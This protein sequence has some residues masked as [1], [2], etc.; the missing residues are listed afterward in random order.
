MAFQYRI[1]SKEQWEARA[2]QSGGDYEGWLKDEYKIY[3]TLVNENCIRI[4]PPS[5]QWDA[6]SP[7]GRAPHYGMDVYVHFGVGPDNASVVCPFKM[8]KGACPVCEERA[9]YE[10]A[11]DEEMSRKL[12]AGKRVL[13]FLV[14]RKDESQGPV[15]W[16]M[17]YTL[18]RD[19][20]KASKDRATGTHYFIDDPAEGFDVYFDRTGESLSTK[21]SGIVLAKSPSPVAEQ[22]LDWVE[23][24]PVPDALR[25]RDY[26]E[27]KRLY[28]GAG[29]GE[30]PGETYGGGRGGGGSGRPERPERP[31]RPRAE[32]NERP[33]ERPLPHEAPSERP[34][35]HAAEMAHDE[36]PHDDSPPFDVE[37]KDEPSS[38]GQSRAEQLAAIRARFSPRG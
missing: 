26:D 6:V 37:P 19:I 23:A 13:V 29:R 9:R 15:A 38:D 30:A 25:W 18:D 5:S 2:N 27:I 36:P 21:Y 33:S 35:G 34:N 11:K 4:L 28:D 1:R 14:N 10:R 16:G 12:R 31:E 8:K 24:H 20:I 17:P 7:G 22:Y 3:K 32:A